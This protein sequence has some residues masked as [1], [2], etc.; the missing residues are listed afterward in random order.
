LAVVVAEEVVGMA[1]AEVLVGI[2]LRL[3][4]L[5]A[6]HLLKLL[7]LLPLAY[8]MQ[9][10]LELAGLAALLTAIIMELM[11]DLLLLGLQLL[12]AAGTALHTQTQG[13]LVALAVAEVEHHR[14]SLGVLVHLVK[15]LLAVME[16][17]KLVTVMVAAVV[18]LGP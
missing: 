11:G 6:V 2:V 9:L 10:L 1:L 13:V 12:L 18:A 17:R 3:V 15:A 5:A 7:L 8:L 14:P 16:I 4:L